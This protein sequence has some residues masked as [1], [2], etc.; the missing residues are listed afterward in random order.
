MNSQIAIGTRAQH[1]PV[2]ARASLMASE[3]LLDATRAPL[4]RR[5]EIV[6]RRLNRITP[7]LGVWAVKKRAALQSRG[8]P[9]DQAIFDSLRL[10]IANAMIERGLEHLNLKI[11]GEYGFDAVDGG[12]GQMS[13]N[14]RATA[15]TVAG[16]AAVVGGVANVVPLYGQIVGAVVGI[17][18]QIA[19]AALDCGRETR[20]AAAAAAQAQANLEA[21]QRAAAE[22]AAAEQ[23][24]SGSRRMRTVLIGGAIAVAALGAG[25]IILSD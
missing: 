9:R 20:D 6:A 24:A 5:E 13:S 12:L 14:D 2:L 4:A 22:R 25:W 11:A 7:G 21:A 17:G 3:I 15:C 10:G 23:A 16:T 19:G 18:S 8:T 1:D